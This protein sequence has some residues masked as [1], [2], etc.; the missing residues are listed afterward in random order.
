MLPY[1]QNLKIEPHLQRKDAFLKAREGRATPMRSRL[2]ASQVK[3]TPC[4]LAAIISVLCVANNRASPVT[5][6]ESAT[7]TGSL[8]GTSFPSGEVLTLTGTGNTTNITN[9]GAGTFFNN[10]TASFTLSV[11]VGGVGSGTFTDA[12]HVFSNQTGVVAGF[13]DSAVTDVLDTLNAAFASYDLS[14]SIGPLTG[15]SFHG[16]GPFPTSAG[17]L[18]LS[19]AGNATWASAVPIPSALPL[20]ATG[21]AGLVLLGWRRKRKAAA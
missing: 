15:P 18:I 21:L 19:A 17:P 4:V 6:T 11:S 10:V 16:T 7:V 2:A 9:D 3:F 13:S 5:Y 14:T 8:N 12:F 20:F 1:V